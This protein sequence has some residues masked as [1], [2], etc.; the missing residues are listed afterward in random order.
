VTPAIAAKSRSGPKSKRQE[1]TIFVMPPG[2][3]KPAPVTVKLGINDGVATEVLE[4]LKE[5]DLVVIGVTSHAPTSSTTAN[6][7]G[8]PQHR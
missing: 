7:F 1:R 5:G 8:G 2:G 4:G 6:P 3:S